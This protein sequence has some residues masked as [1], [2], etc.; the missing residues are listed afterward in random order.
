MTGPELA[1]PAAWFERWARAALDDYPTI[2]DGGPERVFIRGAEA[3]QLLM[4]AY[5]AGWAQARGPRPKNLETR[6]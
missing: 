3:R 1:D 2:C 4:R 5:V 6:L